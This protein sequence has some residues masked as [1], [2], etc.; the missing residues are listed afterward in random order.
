[1]GGLVGIAGST[2]GAVACWWV[3]TRPRSAAWCAVAGTA[4]DG[5]VQAITLGLV[6][7]STGCL[8]VVG[9][10]C[11]ALGQRRL[12]STRTGARAQRYRGR[13]TG[14]GGGPSV[15]VAGDAAAVCGVVGAS[16]VWEVG[17]GGLLGGVGPSLDIL[18][19]GEWRGGCQAGLSR[20]GPATSSGVLFVSRAGWVR[21]LGSIGRSLGGSLV[22]VL[23]AV[24]CS[25]SSSWSVPLGMGCG[26]G[27]LTVAR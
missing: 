20:C 14:A 7:A 8:V 10:G 1:M 21:V 27:G 18:S 2:T 12:G 24:G 3:G 5:W 6:E 13:W 26:L 9:V 11:I 23:G 16:L 17:G 19:G 15:W 25:A 22:W 4:S